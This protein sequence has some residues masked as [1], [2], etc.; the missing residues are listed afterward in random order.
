MQKFIAIPIL[1][2]LLTAS[3]GGRPPP[4]AEERAAEYRKSYRQAQMDC[5]ND[6]KTAA[7]L[8]AEQGWT[9]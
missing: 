2:L 3:C 1:V 6:Y 5:H 4:T 8:M 9:Y 7:D